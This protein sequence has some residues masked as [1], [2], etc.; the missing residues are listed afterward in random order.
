MFSSLC[1]LFLSLLLP[2]AQHPKS[3]VI[4]TIIGYIIN[5]TIT[6]TI[7]VIVNITIAVNFSMLLHQGRYFVLSQQSFHNRFLLHF[8]LGFRL[9]IIT[10]LRHC[11]SRRLI[12]PKII[13]R[14]FNE[15]IDV[16]RR[17]RTLP[18][19]MHI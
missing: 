10:D 13:Q 8:F 17:I 1:A 16:T 7:S 4:V 19:E 3:I 9:T 15:F 18:I 6:A 12:L 11:Y 5:I 14:P 2:H